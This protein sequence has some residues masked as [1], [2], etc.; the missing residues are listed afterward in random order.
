[1]TDDVRECM[2]PTVTDLEKRIKRT[3]PHNGE[4]VVGVGRGGGHPRGVH[5]AVLSVVRF[6]NH[7]LSRAVKH[8]SAVVRRLVRLT[9]TVVN[10]QVSSN[11]H[12]VVVHVGC[13][14]VQQPTQSICTVHEVHVN[15]RQ[16]DDTSAAVNAL[17]THTLGWLLIRFLCGPC[18]GSGVDEQVV[19]H[20]W[21]FK[22]RGRGRSR[23]VVLDLVI[24]HAIR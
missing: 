11:D 23:V 4:R 14:R 7:H 15:A 9:R 16:C 10:Q 1:M 13:T 20:V 12:E 8:L 24:A 21:D 6:V 5:Q 17:D 18:Y 22:R 2:P 3:G 19:R